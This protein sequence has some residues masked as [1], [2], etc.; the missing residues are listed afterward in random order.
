MDLYHSLGRSY[1]RRATFMLADA[2]A[3]AIRKLKDGDSQYM[4]QP[5]LQAGQPDRLLGR[6]VEISDSMPAMT[7]GLKSVLFADFS[8]YWIGDRTA[9]V[10]QR[11][12]ELYAATGQVGYRAFKRVDGKLTLAAAAKHLIQA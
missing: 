11:L 5:G 8:Y 2:T 12:D 4:W 3:L 7:T 6:P 1:R 10:V 9:T